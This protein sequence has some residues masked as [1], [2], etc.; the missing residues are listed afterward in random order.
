MI[1]QVSNVMC[2]A[3]I[4]PKPWKLDNGQEGV[5]YRVEISDGTGNLSLQCI[6]GD[7]HNKFVPFKRHNVTIQLE[8]TNYEGRKGVKGIITYA[9]VQ[10]DKAK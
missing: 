6:D 2:T 4:P 10:D 1:L 5:T 8:Q 3:V 7:I 9:E